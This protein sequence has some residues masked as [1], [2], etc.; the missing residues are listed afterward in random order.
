MAK[1]KTIADTSAEIINDL[2]K[3][4]YKPVYILSGDEHYYIDVISDFIAEDVLSE[5]EKAFNQTIAYGK[6]IDVN[7]IIEISRRFPMMANHQVVIVREAQQI[8]KL[9]ELEVY[10]KAPQKSTILVICHKLAPGAKVGAGLK[11]LFT[12]AGKVGVYFESKRL[13]DNQVPAWI[14]SFLS[15]KGLT[16]S[17]ASAELL[18]DYLGND[19]NKIANE[20]EKLII[21]LADGQ[22]KITTEHIERNIGI[23]KDFNRFELTNAL[24]A[25]DVLK[26]NRI[27]DYFAKNPGPNPMVLST[28]AIYQYFSKV[29]KCHFIADKSERNLAVVLGVNPFFVS[30]YVKASR[31]Y[32]PRKCVQV[33]ELLREYDLRSKGV[34]NDSVDNGELLKEL[35]YKI[36]H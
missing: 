36:L 33:F 12:L 28:M 25:R 5:S 18:K 22:S 4:I 29:F 11:K 24:G 16:L 17:P 19:L 26:A 6:D 34:N 3:K 10:L 15:Q 23:S 32:N 13:Y 7:A 8:K 2:K 1:R 14:A 20:L 21:T 30:D 9:E 27:V 31:I 35:V